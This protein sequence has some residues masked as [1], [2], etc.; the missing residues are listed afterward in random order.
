MNFKELTGLPRSHVVVEFA[1]L[2]QHNLTERG[3]SIVIPKVMCDHNCVETKPGSAVCLYI[4]SISFDW[5][6]LQMSE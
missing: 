5:L 3:D 6:L 4:Q 2:L 1:S